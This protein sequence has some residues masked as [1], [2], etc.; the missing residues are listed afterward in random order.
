[1]WQIL[2][3]VC[4]PEDTSF[5]CLTVVLRK[6]MG[7]I[8]GVVRI[9][10]VGT[11]GL[12]TCPVGMRMGSSFLPRRITSGCKTVGSTAKTTMKI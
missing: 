9:S 2:S 7:R 12:F 5:T 10:G 11:L 8:K 3:L 4:C 6:L 1:M